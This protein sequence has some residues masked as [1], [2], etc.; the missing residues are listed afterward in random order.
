MNRKDLID[1]VAKETGSTK[2]DA[3]RNITAVVNTIV[4]AMVAG[5]SVSLPGFG[6]FETRARAARVGRNPASGAA[7]NIAASRSPA[8]RA[9][10]TLKDAVK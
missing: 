4:T 10:K 9:G 6:V 2:A 1:A 8:F 3:D 5:D 7:V